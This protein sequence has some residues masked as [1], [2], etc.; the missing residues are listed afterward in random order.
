M[1]FQREFQPM[2]IQIGAPEIKGRKHSMSPCGSCGVIRP[3][4]NTGW[5]ENGWNFNI[6]WNKSFKKRAKTALQR[7]AFTKLKLTHAHMPSSAFAYLHS[8]LVPLVPVHPTH[9]CPRYGQVCQGKFTVNGP[10][11][12]W[13]RSAAG[14]EDKSL[15]LKPLPHPTPWHT[16]SALTNVYAAVSVCVCNMVNTMQFGGRHV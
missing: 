7:T 13:R 3:S 1:E 10:I 9:P 6:R 12:W 14:A 16:L 15:C 8:N 4:I 5:I 2:A 11:V